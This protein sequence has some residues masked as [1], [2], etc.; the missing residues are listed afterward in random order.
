MYWTIET[1]NGG[2]E[3]DKIKQVINKIVEYYA[4]S[5]ES[6]YP[7]QYIASYNK[8]GDEKLICDESIKKIEDKINEEILEVENYCEI[9][10]IY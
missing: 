1:A 8:N 3:G 10:P 4:N 7:I 6:F 9:N 5:G 2:F